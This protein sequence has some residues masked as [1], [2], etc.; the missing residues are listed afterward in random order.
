MKYTL[1]LFALT[2]MC[3]SKDDTKIQTF[4]SLNGKWVETETR[5]DTLLFENIDHLDFMYLNRGNEH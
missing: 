3:C 4:L 2:F 5:M 1:L